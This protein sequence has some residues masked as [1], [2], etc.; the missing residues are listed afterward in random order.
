[1]TTKGR[2]VLSFAATTIYGL[3]NAIAA[4][5]KTLALG[6]TAG[7]QF[8]SSDAAYVAGTAMTAFWT[9][10]GVSSLVLVLVLAAIWWAPLRRTLSA[11]ILIALAGAVVPMP[12][13]RAY[14]DNKDVAEITVIMPNE[15]AFWVPDVGDNKSSQKAFDSE[16]YLNAN[17]IA[18]KRFQIPHAKV[19]GSVYWG[20]D[21][22]APT[23]KLYIVDRTPYSREWVEGGRGSSQRDEGFKCQSAEGLDVTTGVTISTFVTEQ[24]AAKFLFHYGVHPPQGNREDPAVIF[25]SIL[26]GRSLAEVMDSK[27]RNAVQA[28][29]CNEIMRH[30]LVFDNEHAVDIMTDVRKSIE[31]YLNEKGIS[32]DFIGWADT[33]GFSGKVQDALDRRFIAEEDAKIAAALGPST[34]VI[35][36][37]AVAEALRNKWNGQT[38]ASVS[39]TF[40]PAG[41]TDFLGSMLKPFVTH[42]PAPA[43][44]AGK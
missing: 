43:S 23:G 2:I 26:Y 20:W 3:V 34:S 4:P 38:P 42:A 16:E 25:T 27:V 10:L 13:A 28:L 41:V 22:F 35:Q 8:A 1:M 17:K 19:S 11:L 14:W 36:Q 12:E 31:P 39:M 33:F 32:L 40:V 37:L 15:S 24:N 9:R 30:T 21:N 18:S 7:L 5:V 6:Q 44:P 29:V